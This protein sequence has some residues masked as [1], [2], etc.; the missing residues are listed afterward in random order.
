MKKVALSLALM[1]FAGMAVNTV[2]VNETVVVFK[3]DN[4][5]KKKKKGSCCASKTEGASC[6]SKTGSTET[7]SCHSSEKK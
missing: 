4:K 3:K 1:M 7:K 2:Y 5:K 6:A